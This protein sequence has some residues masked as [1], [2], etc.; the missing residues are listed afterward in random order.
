MT[1]T[2]VKGNRTFTLDTTSD[3]QF[4]ILAE[5]NNFGGTWT[6]EF[7]PTL[8]FDGALVVMARAPGRNAE[9]NPP[10]FIPIQYRA[11]YLNGAMADPSA[12]QTAPITS[13]SNITINAVGRSIAFLCTMSAGSITLYTNGSQQT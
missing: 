10:A 6:V 12:V 13:A 5:P 3:A 7:A 4:V 11:E 1:T 8:D 9:Q 2:A